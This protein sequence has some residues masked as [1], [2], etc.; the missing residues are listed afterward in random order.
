MATSRKIGTKSEIGIRESRLH[1]ERYGAIDDG[2]T[3]SRRG[4]RERGEERGALRAAA[5]RCSPLDGVHVRLWVPM[6]SN[7]SLIPGIAQSK[8]RQR[9]AERLVGY[10]HR[11][12]C[13]WSTSPSRPWLPF[14]ST[15]FTVDIRGFYYSVPSVFLLYAQRLA[16]TPRLTP[17]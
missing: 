3:K 7:W 17:T 5:D 13:N 12:D 8:N 4:G 1:E 15:V 2:E 6:A 11:E 16:H 14:A 9:T 10:G